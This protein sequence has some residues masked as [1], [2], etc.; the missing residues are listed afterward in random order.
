MHKNVNVKKFEKRFNRQ[1]VML[2]Y[3][4]MPTYAMGEYEVK[5]ASTLSLEMTENLRTVLKTISGFAAD[6]AFCCYNNQNS[7]FRTL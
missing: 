4:E 6:I 2:E 3:Q 7:N 5:T 1:F